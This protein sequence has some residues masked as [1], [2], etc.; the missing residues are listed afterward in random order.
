LADLILEREPSTF[1]DAPRA[2]PDR[3][4]L[5]A[6]DQTAFEQFRDRLMAYRE[7]ARQGLQEPLED[8]FPVTRSLLEEAWPPCVD[9]FLEARRIAS[10]H[11]R[12]IGPAFLGWLVET[13][14]G[15]ERWPFL[16]ELA[17]FEILEVLVARYPDLPGP[18]GLAPEPGADRSLVL[19]PAAQVVA[20]THAVHRAT[21]AFPVPP[22]VPAWILAYRDGEGE[23]RFLELT[24]ATAALLVRA[25][26][27][28]A[29]EAAIALGL[30]NPGDVLPFLE[31]LRLKGAIAGFLPVPAV[32]RRRWPPGSSTVPPAPPGP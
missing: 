11:Y 14:W 23:A 3:R 22:A 5:P 18:G 17:H 30:E 26:A 12:D 4:G 10:P 6:R 20:Y 21:V 16:G 29:G 19:D 25:Q 1:P 7:L 8:L 15:A 32:S 24:E 13:G 27:E 28:G 2:F 9:A 31:D